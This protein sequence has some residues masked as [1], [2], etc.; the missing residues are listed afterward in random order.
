MLDNPRDPPR[1][2]KFQYYEGTRLLNEKPL[3]V[4]WI[5][6]IEVAS[7]EPYGRDEVKVKLT[8]GSS[9]SVPGPVEDV[10][11]RLR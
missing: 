1:F 9:Y 8:N 2:I 7:L 3:G 4:V 10:I 11:R 6:P 5:N